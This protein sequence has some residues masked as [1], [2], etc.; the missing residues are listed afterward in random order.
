MWL[1]ADPPGGGPV[2]DRGQ[3][4]AGLADDGES[5]R[6]RLRPSLLAAGVDDALMEINAQLPTSGWI[7]SG[8]G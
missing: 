2:Q 6:E 7:G 5:A 8:A 3:H 1:E 4:R